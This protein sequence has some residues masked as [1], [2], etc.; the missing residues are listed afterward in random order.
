MTLIHIGFKP[1]QHNNTTDVTRPKQHFT[2]IHVHDTVLCWFQYYLNIDIII[3]KDNNCI[4]LRAV[5]DSINAIRDVAVWDTAQDKTKTK[6][7]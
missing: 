1:S 2:D 6:T 3:T 7:Q 5:D 4:I